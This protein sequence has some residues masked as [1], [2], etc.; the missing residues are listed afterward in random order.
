MASSPK[1]YNPR[2]FYV[3]NPDEQDQCQFVY[4]SKDDKKPS[5]CQRDGM[6]RIGLTIFLCGVHMP[7]IGRHPI[8][9]PVDV[10]KMEKPIDSDKITSPTAI[11]GASLTTRLLEHFKTNQ[12]LVLSYSQ[13]MTNFPNIDNRSYLSI[14]ISRLRSEKGARILNI[15]SVGYKYLG[16]NE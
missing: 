5:R 14:I 11:P 13:L 10:K 9:N 15:P 4:Q 12:G 2:V 8:I 1:N 6:Y 3:A 16:V 7:G